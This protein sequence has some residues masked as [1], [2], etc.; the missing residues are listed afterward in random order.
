[1][2][3][4]NNNIKIDASLRYQST[5]PVSSDGLLLQLDKWGIEYELSSHIPLMTVNQ[6]KGVQNKF[7][8]SAEGGGI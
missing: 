3:D 8:S 2:I 4:E 5:L 7:L 6:S 1:M